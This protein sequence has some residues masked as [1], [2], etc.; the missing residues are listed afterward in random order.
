[1]P[2]FVRKGTGPRP[3]KI[4][5]KK[6]GKVVGSA[7]TKAEAQASVKARYANTSEAERKY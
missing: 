7:K 6:T 1:M 2:W 5:S 4:V 3:W